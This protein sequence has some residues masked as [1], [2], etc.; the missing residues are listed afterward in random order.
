LPVKTEV[1]A[2]ADIETILPIG[3]TAYARLCGATLVR[4][5]A[6]GGDVVAIDAYIG[7]DETFTDALEEFAQVY[8]DQAEQDFGQLKQ[9]ISDG[10]I[11]IQA[12]V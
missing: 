1:Q 7:T 10:K 9:A 2:T 11:P 5:H 6:R 4:A 8:A 12:G 3:L